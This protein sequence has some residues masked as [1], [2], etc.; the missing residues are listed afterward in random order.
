VV[1]RRDRVE[2]SGHRSRTVRISEHG[3]LFRG[4]EKG[5][6]HRIVADMTRHGLRTQPL[7]KLALVK[8]RLLSEFLR[9]R[10]ANLGKCGVDSE[11]VAKHDECPI[12]SRTKIADY[13]ANELIERIR[14]H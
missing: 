3:G 4:E 7:A 13:P 14:V 9:A 2:T 12:Y 11:T 6:A 10:R 8:A 1:K 5:V